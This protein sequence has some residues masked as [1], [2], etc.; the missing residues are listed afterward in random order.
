MQIEAERQSK[1]VARHDVGCWTARAS[2]V[3]QTLWVPNYTTR[4]LFSVKKLA[5][6]GGELTFGK[7]AHI[8]TFGGCWRAMIYLLYVSLLICVTLDQERTQW[9]VSRRCTKWRGIHEWINLVCSPSP[10]K[11]DTGAVAQDAGAQQIQR[12]GTPAKAGERYEN[13]GWS[14]T[15]PLWHLFYW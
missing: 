10:L 3:K 4:N 11:S 15:W 14:W 8:K 1:D 2:S 6:Q 7:D 9:T 5:Q 13:C 12:C